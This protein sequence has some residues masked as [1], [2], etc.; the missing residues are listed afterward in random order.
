METFPLN[1]KPDWGLNDQVQANVTKVKFGDSY[2][3]RQPNGINYLQEG[4]SLGW[5]NLDKDQALQ[6]YA[7][8]K[9]RLSLTAFYW[10]HPVTG[11]RFKVICGNCSLT[12]AGYDDYKLSA[13][14]T[15][16]FNPA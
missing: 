14:F 9:Q 15:Q 3:L 4:W 6:I 12:H 5:S 1:D 10:T 13:T 7:W 16:D 11:V 8:L 2:E